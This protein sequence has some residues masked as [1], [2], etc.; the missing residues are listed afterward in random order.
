MYEGWMNDGWKE[1]R[2]GKDDGW[3]VG[4]LSHR[5]PNSSRSHLTRSGRNSGVP[6]TPSPSIACSQAASLGQAHMF[7]GA[8][9][10]GSD[11]SGAPQGWSWAGHLIRGMWFPAEHS[12]FCMYVRRVSAAGCCWQPTAASAP[13]GTFVN[14]PC[15]LSA[16]PGRHGDRTRNGM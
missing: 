9:N 1:E 8:A 7:W 6:A 13:Q 15:G 16:S 14:P 2:E 12:G 4:Y 5:V 10:R 11:S 3:V